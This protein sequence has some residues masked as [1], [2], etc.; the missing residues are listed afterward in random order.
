MTRIPHLALGVLLSTGLAV[1][2]VP[3]EKLRMIEVSDL[4]SMQKDS[5]SPPTLLDANDAEFRQKNGVIPGAKL[6]SSFDR[7]DLAK[8]LPADK[9]A[10]L[11]FYCA[12][13]L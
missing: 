6:L 1:A 7:Y 13:R 3:K 8:E 4:E 12:D 5:K 2:A 11:V 10:P 9:N